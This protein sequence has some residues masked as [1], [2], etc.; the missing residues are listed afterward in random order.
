[1]YDA[2]HDDIAAVDLQC[3]VDDQATWYAFPSVQPFLLT[4]LARIEMDRGRRDDAA[5][6]VAPVCASRHPSIAALDLA[7]LCGGRATSA[8]GAP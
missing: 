4:L 3:A 5:R 8:D 2:D 6:I 1:M 7:S